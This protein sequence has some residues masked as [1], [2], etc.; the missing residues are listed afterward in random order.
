MK[1]VTTLVAAAAVALAF[2]ACNKTNQEVTPEVTTGNTYAS[3]RIGQAQTRAT[4][5]DEN[6]RDA[7]S[8][9]T[10]VALLLDQELKTPGVNQVGNFWKTE[11]FNTEAGSRTLAL[12][13]NRPEGL[14]LPTLASE[15]TGFAT[16][17]KTA[18]EFSVDG[19]FV[20]TSAQKAVTVTANIAKDVVDA[21]QAPDESKN[22]FQLDV[23]RVV[24][25][26]I[27]VDGTGA[28]EGKVATEDKLGDLSGLKYGGA[29][30]A[31]NTYLF[32]DN[33]GKRT[34]GDDER[35]NDYKSVVDAIHTKKV[36]PAPADDNA[37]ANFQLAELTDRAL[38]SSAA[39]PFEKAGFYFFENSVAQVD[40]QTATADL[41]AHRNAYAKV[42]GVYTPKTVYDVEWKFTEG[43]TG[44]YFDLTD[45]NN[46][47]GVDVTNPDEG[48]PENVKEGSVTGVRKEVTDF[49]PGTTF[50]K[51][52][53][54]KLFYVSSAAAKVYNNQKSYMYEGGKCVY[55]TPWNQIKDE[56]N[57]TV[58]ADTRRNNI[59][60]LTVTKFEKVGMNYDPNDPQDP[61]IPKP[62]NPDEPTTPPD[63]GDPSWDKQEGYMTVFSEI[64]PWNKVSRDVVL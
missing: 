48:L 63:G 53:D 60:V 17:G 59:Y 61:N 29:M 2:T 12:V 49:K 24:A 56:N 43:E 18:A 36:S 32:A 41:G 3:V 11:S 13:V 38:V 19:S 52:E 9:V 22:G 21:L 45:P 62:E 15:T 54:D 35:Y 7:E 39:T 40:G 33:A 16:S 37:R 10:G 23:E 14:T 26:G 8:A 51:G 44:K 28:A 34:M 6:G 42:Y 58:Y 57:L 47:K 50:F 46:P 1:K 25:Q 20:M 5:A 55:R 27:V 30:G 31:K 4:E 64:R